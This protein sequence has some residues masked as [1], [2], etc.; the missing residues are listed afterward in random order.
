MPYNYNDILGMFVYPMDAKDKQNQL[1]T[2]LL[3]TIQQ[4]IGII[5]Y[6]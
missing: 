3:I 6:L 5:I 2:L 4:A 1:C